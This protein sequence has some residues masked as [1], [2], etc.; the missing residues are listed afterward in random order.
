M[1]SL[2]IDA[3]LLPY[4]HATNEADSERMLYSLVS[5]CVE[6]V[7]RQVIRSKLRVYFDRDGRASNNPDAEDLYSET[8]LQMLARL[9]ECK[10]NPKD[11]SIGDLRGYVAVVSYHACYEYLR[12][13]Y[14]QRH[15]LK[16]KL[17]YLLT[18]QPS[19][20]LW[21]NESGD[22]LG[23]FTGWRDRTK[24]PA[25]SDRLQ[26]LLNDPS[27]AMRATLPR[28]DF[29]RANQ[30]DLAA[31]IFKHT[32]HPI[33][34]DDLVDIVAG[35][36]GIKDRAEQ[37]A[38]DEDADP[39]ARV[40]QQGSDVASEVDNRLFL[41]WLWE[42]ICQLP[43]RQRMALLLNLRDDQGGGIAA[44]L[45]VTG[46]ASIRQIAAALEMAAEDFAR[47]WPRLPLDDA[48]IAGLLSITRQQVI[49]LRKSAR[50]RLARRMKAAHEK[51]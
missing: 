23:G 46:V 48:S 20:A 10:A 1:N 32:N 49:N 2:Q 43:L 21:E 42:E 38:R 15:N 24:T 11:K 31:A 8:L 26:Q 19:L 39:L 51:K 3:R 47:L 44:L 45:P 17:R 4:I 29:R 35:L 14:P 28:G 30:A 12:L 40:A 41:K 7:I 22:L 27:A 9:K 25:R 34:L 16:N 37:S 6:P 18:H 33:E 5:E 50:E 36:F 13:K